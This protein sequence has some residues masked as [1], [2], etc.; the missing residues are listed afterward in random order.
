MENIPA[1]ETKQLLVPKSRWERALY[2]LIVIV[3]PILCFSLSFFW[4]DILKPEWQSGE[5]SDY[6]MLM[7]LPGA[8]IFFFPFMAYAIVS[9]VLLQVAPER[10][11]K[12]FI[13]RFGIH[14]GTILA[15]QYAIFTASFTFTIGLGFAA[16]LFFIK[17]LLGKIKSRFIATGIVF[18]L[19]ILA[20][21]GAMLWMHISIP[22]LSFIGLIA[23]LSASPILCLAI[24]V[25]TSFKLLK[26]YKTGAF[27]FGQ[28]IGLLVWLGSYGLAW[29]FSVLKAIEVYKSLPPQPPS[30]YIATAAARG[31]KSIVRSQPVVLQ[32]GLLWV[33]LQLQYL[34]C[35][36]LALQALAPKLHHCL[37]KMYDFVGKAMAGKLKNPSLA[38]LAY[39]TLKPLEWLTRLVLKVLIPEIDL[40]AR[41]LYRQ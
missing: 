37:R 5:F 24:T 23:I 4:S 18:L 28:G 16:I 26:F 12:R 8:T 10:F 27:T 25:V 1:V 38:D 31:H 30:C 13:I 29:R 9:I 19:F 33:N 14:T 35:A 22:Q 15:L 36:E 20:G 3:L 34:K 41:E 40:V 21:I 6:A 2:A 17:W 39:L 32:S 7:I 11:A